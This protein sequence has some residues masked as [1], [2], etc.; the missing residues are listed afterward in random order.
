MRLFDFR[1]APNPR[2]A[3]IFI[4]EKG[5]S[6]ERVNIDLYRMQ[7]L[8]PEFL[9]INPLGTVPVLETDDGTY[10]AETLAIC[11]YLESQHPEPALMGTSPT[12]QAQ[13]LMWNNVVEQ[14]G[15]AAIAEGLRNWSP[16]FRNRVFPGRVEYEQL[17]QLIERGKARAEQF[18]DLME[19][20]LENKR[21]LAGDNFTLADISLL[22]MTEFANWI[23]IQPHVTRPA[24]ARWY[25]SVAARPSASA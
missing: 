15:M 21:Y 2:R 4:A 16:G 14:H 3:R 1:R 25:E 10:L 5:L 24:L 17:P 20:Q 18:F 19:S 9:Q 6:I 23:E 12:E 11:H 7:Q 22:S 13:V 8:S